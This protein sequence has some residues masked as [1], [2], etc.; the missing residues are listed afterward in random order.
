MAQNNKLRADLFPPDFKWGVATSAFQTEGESNAHGKGPSIWD[1]FIEP[2]SHL[3]SQGAMATDFYNKYIDDIALIKHLNLTDFRFSMSWARLFPDGTGAPNAEGVEFYNG[4][5]DACLKSNITPWITLYHWDLPQKLQD[6]GGWANRDI[7]A[8][9]ANFADF[10]TATF[11]KKV[12]HWMVLNEPMSFTGL[13]YF[14]GYHAPGKSGLRQFLPAAHHA[15]L[16][17]A[18]GGR[19]IRKNIP[20]AIIGTT[21]SC[22]HVTPKNGFRRNRMAAKRLDAIL[23]RFFIEPALGMGY[24]YDEIPGLK[25]IEKYVLPGD[26]QKLK[27]DFDFIGLQY[28]FRVVARF[29]LLAP[30]IYAKE[31]PALKRG[32]KTNNMGMEIYP[33]G[34]YKTLKK[35]S[36]YKGVKAIY[37]TESGICLDDTLENGAV[38][39]PKR[40][41]YFRKTFRSTLKAI[42][43]DVK[44]KGYFFWTLTDNFEWAEGIK[45]RFG[46]IYNDFTTQV[47]TIKKSG[48]WVKSFLQNR[49]D[50]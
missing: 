35:F 47:R 32:V 19:I 39:D 20:H 46:L 5:I 50:K 14:M 3:S 1:T 34:L 21:F 4:V 10:C 42:K 29:S 36:Q 16:C 11:G 43:N 25:R 27:F 33:K 24:P 9:F 40:I 17:Q 44:V 8:W 28:Y 30:I 6:S 45:P 31:I 37:I 22:S 13:G 49:T 2:K 23:N 26:E 12:T 48:Y 15:A 41:R 7:V 38:N 18:E